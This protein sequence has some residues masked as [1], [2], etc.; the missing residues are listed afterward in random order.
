MRVFTAF[1][2]FLVLGSF[3]CAPRESKSQL[4]D[5]IIETQGLRQLAEQTKAATA[6]EAK[7]AGRMSYGQLKERVPGL[8]KETLEK[9]RLA[10]EKYTETVMAAWSVEDSMAVWKENYGAEFSEKELKRTA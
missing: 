8:Q 10:S 1:A 4:V 9:I 2:V 5:K 3:G 6:A 7:E